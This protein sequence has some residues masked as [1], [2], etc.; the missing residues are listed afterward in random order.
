M[1]ERAMVDKS[2]TK[3]RRLELDRHRER[4]HNLQDMVDAFDI[5]FTRG[6]ARGSGEFPKESDQANG[7]SYPWR[8]SA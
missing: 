4:A 7:R 5:I 8:T 2:E 6:M 1:H 3:K